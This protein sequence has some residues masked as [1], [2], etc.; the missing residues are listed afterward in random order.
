VVTTSGTIDSPGLEGY[1]QFDYLGGVDSSVHER[2]FALVG[3]PLFETGL[4]GIAIILDGSDTQY[5]E[6]SVNDTAFDVGNEG[7]A[8]QIWVS[9]VSTEDEQ[10]LIEK[11][12]QGSDP[13][14]CEG[15]TLTKLS[16]DQVRFAYSDGSSGGEQV[17]DSAQ[18]TIMPDVWHQLVVRRG[19]A[20]LDLFFDGVSIATGSIGSV[21]ITPSPKPLIIGIREGNNHGVNGRIDEV[22]FWSRALDDAEITRLYNYGAG[23][24]II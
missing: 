24:Q 23:S 6:R 22:A 20:S 12:T 8:I 16:E 7:F 1:W 2:R 13:I 19:G 4:V 18:L 14:D 9:F 10:T 17:V 15:Y 3:S 11:W 21:T 5:A